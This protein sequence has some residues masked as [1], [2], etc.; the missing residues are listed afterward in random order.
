MFN[1][2][3]LKSCHGHGRAGIIKISPATLPRRE[4]HR[5]S[6]SAA[7]DISVTKPP[8]KVLEMSKSVQSCQK[9]QKK[10]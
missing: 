3:F 5:G 7:M 8:K 10:E 2:S 6:G 9:S 1:I 4:S